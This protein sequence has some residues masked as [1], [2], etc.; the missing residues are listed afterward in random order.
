MFAKLLRGGLWALVVLG[1]SSGTHGLCTN[2]CGSG[3]TD[4]GEACLV[5]L[6]VD[7]PEAYARMAQVAGC[8]DEHNWWAEKMGGFIEA[9]MDMAFTAVAAIADDRVVAVFWTPG[10]CLLSNQAIPCIHADPYYGDLPPGESR[11]ARGM[12]IF[13]RAP[14]EALAKALRAEAGRPWEKRKMENEK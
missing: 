9:P 3:D 6:A 10:K 14:L 11:S 5:D 12:V 1:L 8:P 7:R 4:E 2:D 13:T